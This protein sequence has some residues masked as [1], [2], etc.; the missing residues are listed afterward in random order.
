MGEVGRRERE[1]VCDGLDFSLDN[2]AG[3]VARAIRL[4]GPLHE[5]AIC[6]SREC[7][8]GEGWFWTRNSASPHV[9]QWQVGPRHPAA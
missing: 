3:A 9:W 4:H 2:G 8:L 5:Q 7:S 6:I 1:A